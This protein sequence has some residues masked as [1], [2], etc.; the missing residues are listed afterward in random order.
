V[1]SILRFGSVLLLAFFVL[2]CD[3]DN[4]PTP[5]NQGTASGTV[6]L[7]ISSDKDAYVS[8]GRTS[9]C[10]EGDLNYG[11]HDHLVVAGGQNGRK[12]AYVHFPIPNVPEGTEVLEAYLE[13]FHSGKN[14]DGKTDDI[15]IPFGELQQGFAPL[16]VTW[17][18]RPDPGT[19]EGQY[20]IKLHSQAWSGSQ[21]IK[22]LVAGYLGSPES[23][24]GFFL[25]WNELFHSGLEIEK[26]FYSNNEKD[27]TESDLSKAPRLLVKI[28]L[29]D[30]KTTDDMTM[31][32]M[33]TDNDLKD[34]TRPTL[35]L[36]YTQGDWPATW[37][38]TRGI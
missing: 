15:D 31:P 10:E 13:L 23:H 19:T 22:D 28:K 16:T 18:T 12:R 27:R 17:N 4:N 36:R 9:S 29:P 38:V 6:S 35:M 20:R 34:L 8:C 33:T 3:E 21:D 11:T 14:E 5:P 26:G 7:W 30:G 2:S 25:A 37:E 24:L 32:F 1:N